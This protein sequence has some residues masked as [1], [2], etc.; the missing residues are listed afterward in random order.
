MGIYQTKTMFRGA[1]VRREFLALAAM[2][3]ASCASGSGKAGEPAAAQSAWPLTHHVR[4]LAFYGLND[5]N[6]DVPPSFMAAR[7]DMVEDDGFAAPHADAFKR[8]GGATAISYTDPTYVPHCPPPFHPPAGRCEGPVGN[9][10]ADDE[11]AWLHDAD[12]ER[13]RRFVSPQF[14]YQEILAVGSTSAR[15]A[16]ALTTS[17]IRS[18]SPLLDGFEADDSGGS[19]TSVDGVFGSSLWGGFNA[20]GVE[21]RSDEQWIGAESA[22]LAAAGKPVIVN[23][24]GPDW[25]PA[26]DGRFIDLPYV[27][28]QQF[29]GCFNNGT[30][31]GYLYTER[32]DTF[33]KA[34]NGLLRVQAHHKLAICYPTGDTSPEHRLYA[35]ASWLL[36]YDPQTSVYEMAVPQSDGHALY[37]ETGLV[38]LGASESV[39][40]I[41]DLLQGGVYARE[42]TACSIDAVPIGPCAAVV[43]ASSGVNADVPPL[44]L[45]YEHHVALDPQSLYAGGQARVAAG[46]P[47]VLAPASAALLVR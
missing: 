9:L 36:V 44:K 22:M 23:G 7:A 19:I 39:A 13:V 5:V 14:Q 46:A 18:K 38:P 26:Y 33:R 27:M 42:F 37:P 35:Y 34:A 43:N 2:T 24:S 31:S 28:G 40:T 3:F 30:G 47:A 45:R 25:G 15:R 4:T 32:G 11:S 21:L 1:A 17:A 12:G 6:A 41:D 16:Y 8:A 10:V 20:P 29:E